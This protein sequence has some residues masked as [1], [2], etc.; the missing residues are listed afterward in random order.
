MRGLEPYDRAKRYPIARYPLEVPDVI[1]EPVRISLV[2]WEG[3][4][5]EA[6]VIQK[7]QSHGPPG[8]GSN[9]ELDSWIK[10]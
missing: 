6:G 3:I 4:R 5:R 1:N 2:Q 8:S 7:I 9:A 10:T